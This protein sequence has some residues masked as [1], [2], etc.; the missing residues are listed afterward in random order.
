LFLRQVATIPGLSPAISSNLAKALVLYSQIP[1]TYQI[2]SKFRN[3]V[4]DLVDSTQI[5]F[6][7]RSLCLF[8]Y[9]FFSNSSSQEKRLLTGVV[10]PGSNLLG[11][12]YDV[13][14]DDYRVLPALKLNLAV[15]FLSFPF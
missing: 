5:S 7:A 1:P 11:M 12:S 4:D 13:V 2:S 15:L 14:A 3:E 6:K 10:I 8:P 9:L